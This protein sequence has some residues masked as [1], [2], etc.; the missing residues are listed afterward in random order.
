MREIFIERREKSIRIAVKNN[1]ELEECF[2]EEK[3]SEPTYGEIYKGRVKNIVPAINSLFLDIGLDKEGYMYYS[4]DLKKLN[5]KKGDE[6]LVEVLKEPLNEKGAKLTNKFNIPGKYLVFTK[7]KKGISFS[8]RITDAVKKKLIEAEL[9]DVDGI[10]IVVRTEAINVPIEIL[11]AERNKL[12]GIL[13]EMNRKLNY[14][15]ELSKVYGEDVS[16]NKVL[17]DNITKGNLK[18]Y[19]DNIEDETY[20]KSFLDGEKDIEIIV[21]DGLRTL[22]DYYNI[23]KEI[24]KLRHNKVKLNCGGDIVIEKTEAMYVI[25][26][27]SGKNI[28]GRSFDKTIL[29]TNLEAAKEIGKQIMLRNLSGI[30]LIDFIDMRDHSQRNNVMKEL[31]ESLK[32]DKGNSKIYPFTELDL[33]Q[34]TRKRRG[35]SIYD[36]IED[37]CLL[38]KGSGNI[39]KL[40]YIEDLIRNDILRSVEDNT[41]GSFFIELDNIYREDVKGDLFSFLKNIDGLDKEMFL[42]FSE[43]IDGYRIEPLIFKNQKENLADYKVKG[44]E[45]Y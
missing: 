6:F 38:C 44:I 11:K 39:L 30:I 25:D 45:K 14:S 13:D 42:K 4:E 19:V 31:K 23:E 2:I 5:I 22:F 37:K 18:I 36:S 17:R 34:I 29:Q 43:G 9:E 16:L 24:L 12:K 21:Y 35:K 8:K 26:V 32:S 33:V 27:N 10:N 1:N 41:I 3:S 7:G 20:V 40:S 28:K 15:T